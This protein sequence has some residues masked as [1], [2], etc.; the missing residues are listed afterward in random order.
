MIK[1]LLDSRIR[2]TV[3]EDGGDILFI[4]KIFFIKITNTK[5]CNFSLMNFF[6]VPVFM[7]TCFNLQLS[8]WFLIENLLK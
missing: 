4:V 2:P 8:A 7:I 1:E 5:L 6:F 3:Q